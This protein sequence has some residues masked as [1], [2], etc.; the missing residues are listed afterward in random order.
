MTKNELKDLVK[1]Y[2]NLEDKKDDKSLDVKSQKFDRAELIDGTPIKNDL[3]EAFAPGQKLFV[4]TEEGETVQAPSGEHQTKGGILIT[5]DGEGIITGIKRPE[6]E[7]EGS[8]AEEDEMAEMPDKGPAKMLSEDKDPN[9]EESSDEPIKMAEADEEMAEEEEMEE[10]DIKEAIIE[11]IMAEVAPKIEMMEEKLDNCMSK[12]SEHED[13]LKEH[14]SSVAAETPTKEKR[15]S[16]SNNVKAEP[17]RKKR[18]NTALSRINV[19]S[20]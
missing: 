7:G 11:A 14:M 4:E 13:K 6:G 12:L 9:S 19:K 8:L 5:V 15:F 1:S 2:F 16:K 18:Y 20:N 3:D 10:G 17:L